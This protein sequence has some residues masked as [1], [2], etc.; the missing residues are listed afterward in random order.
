MFM[1]DL[2]I[3]SFHLFLADL[4]IFKQYELLEF[5]YSPA[6][7]MITNLCIPADQLGHQ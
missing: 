5:A 2:Y 6:L 7:S 3:F 4:Y 1:A